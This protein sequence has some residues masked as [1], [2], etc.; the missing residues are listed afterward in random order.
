MLRGPTKIDLVFPAEARSW[1]PAWEP[2]ATTLRAIDLHSWDWI[3]WLEQK[4]CGGYANVLQNGLRD[5][6]ELMLGPMGV[7]GEP[8]SIP[9]AI[10]IYLEAR[11]ELEQRFGIASIESLK[12]RFAP[13]SHHASPRMHRID[14]ILSAS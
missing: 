6:Y 7:A 8:V 2:S 14:I 1:S 10:R 3:L 13:P 5:M 12:P 4:R 9:D 11:G